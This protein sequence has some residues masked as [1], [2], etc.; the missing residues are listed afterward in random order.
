MIDIMHLP[1]H[2]QN[3]LLIL[4]LTQMSNQFLLSTVIFT[5]ERMSLHT[6]LNVTSM[7]VT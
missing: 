4:L 3:G 7:N 2:D 1:M 6:I 5:Y